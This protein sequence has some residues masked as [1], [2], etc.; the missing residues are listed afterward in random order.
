VRG[1]DV[2]V[3]VSLPQLQRDIRDPTAMKDRTCDVANEGRENSLQSES[4]KGQGTLRE[5]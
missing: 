3:T 5:C 2:A 1:T 4:G